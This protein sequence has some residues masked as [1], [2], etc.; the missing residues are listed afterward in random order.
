MTDT[1]AARAQ[2]LYDEGAAAL[3]TLWDDAVAMVRY[4]DRLEFHDP[5]TTL[6]HAEALLRRGDET[7]VAIAE[8]GIAAVLALQETRPQ[9]AHYGN[10]RWML[11]EECVRDLNAVEFFLDTLSLILREHGPRLS[12]ATLSALH[13]AIALGLDEIDRLDVHP[14]YT[15]IVL[16]DICNSVVG[17]PAIGDARYIERGARRLDEWLEFTSQS[18]APHE[19]NSPTY[20]AVDLERLACLAEYADDPAVAL[21]ARVAEERIWLHVAAHYHAGLA[22][23]AGPHARSYFDGS[24]GAGGYLKLFLWRVLGDDALR[25]PSPYGVG[26][27]EEGHIGVALAPFHCPAYILEWLRAK[28]MPFEAHET[29]DAARGVDLTTYMTR[30]YAIGTASR[31]YTVGSNP[32]QSGQPNSL[33]LQFKRDAAPGFGTLTT[34]FVIDDRDGAGNKDL[35]DEGSSI[36]AQHR[37]RAIVAAGLTPRVRPTRSYKLSVRLLGVGDATEVWIGDRCVDDYPATVKPGEP[38]VIAEGGAYIALIPLE[39]T[40]MGSDAPIE[41]RRDGTRL[42]LE[43]YNYLGPAKMFWEYASLGGAFFKGNV[44][45]ACVIEVAE[46]HEFADVAAFRRHIAGARIADGTDEEYVRE[47]A[48]SSAGGSVALRYNLWDMSPVARVY[49]GVAYTP[50]M[51][52]AGA[53]SGGVRWLQSRDS[54]IELGHAK[55]IAGSAPKWLVADNDAGHYVFVN[56]TDEE[57]PLWFET[58]DAVVECAS[59]GFARI[60]IDGPANIVAIEATGEIDAVRIHSAAFPRLTI[61]GADVTDALRIV[62]EGVRE[63]AGL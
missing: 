7:S 22:Q 24:T 20:C 35:W 38:V 39:A 10:F 63:F 16:S 15:N 14:S 19:Y 29:S 1:A 52:R 34:R 3:A 59:I 18:G 8:R 13:E 62:S 30:G 61:N 36:G 31:S 60:E 9:D 43:I 55:L 53:A 42:T 25:P 40:D 48:Y 45:N 49:D 56:P 58:P 2:Q 4:P 37:N 23:V 27:R 11:E 47:I 5:R 51:A 21:K 44:R 6:A 28:T 50:P 41:L 57:S 54:L 33:L 26:T 32:E 12:A 17:G 46:R